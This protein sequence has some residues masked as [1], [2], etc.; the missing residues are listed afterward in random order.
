MAPGENAR[1][2]GEDIAAGSPIRRRRA[3][4]CAPSMPGSPAGRASPTRRSPTPPS[5]CACPPAERGWIEG[6]LRRRRRRGAR[7][8]PAS[9]PAAALVLALGVPSPGWRR[10][11]G[12]ALAGGRGRGRRRGRRPAVLAGPARP[13]AVAALALAARRAGLRAPA[14][15]RRRARPWRRGPLTRKACPPGSA[16]PRSSSSATAA[17]GLEPLA[18]GS[19]PLVALA[20][21]G[22]LSHP[23]AGERGAAARHARR[24]L[25]PVRSRDDPS[26]PL[27]ADPTHEALRQEQ[28]LTVLSRDEALRRFLAALAP[29]PL[30]RESV[31]ARRQRSAACSPRRSPRPPT[32][33]PSTAPASTASPL[34]AADARGGERGLARRRSPSTPRSSPAASRRA[35]RS[36][37]APRRR[38]PPAAPIP[39]GADAVVMVEHTEPR[40]ADGRLLRPPRAGPGPARRLRRLRHRPRRDAAAARHRDRLARDRHARRLR[41]RRGAGLAPAAGRRALDRRRARRG[42]ASRCARPRSTTRTARS[43]PPPSP[44]TAASRC[45][46]ASCRT[47]RRPSRRRCAR[48]HR[49]LRRGDPLRRHLEGGGRS[50]L[51][52]RR[53]ASARPGIVA[54]GVA[55]KPGKPLCLAVC[56]GKPVVVLPGFPTSAM[57]TFHDF[58][59]PVLRRLAGLPERDGG[60]RRRRALPLRVPRNS[61]APSSCMVVPR[62]AARTASSPTRPPRARAPSPPS[63]R[64]T[65]SSR[66]RRSPTTLPAG[67]TVRGARCSRRTAA[68]RPRRHRQPLHRP[69]RRRRTGSPSAASRPALLAVG[70]LGGLAAAA[71]GRVR[72][73]ADPPPRSGDRHLQRALPRGRPRARPGLAAHAGRRLPPGRPALRGQRRA[74][75]RSRAALADP[76]CL[77]VNRNQ[78]AGT[79][80]LIDGLLAGARPDGLLEPA[81]VPQRRRRGGGAGARRL[82]RR[83]RA[84]GAGLR[85]RLPAARRGAL[86]FRR[87][88]ERGA[89]AAGGGGVPGAPVARP[90]RGDRLR[91]LGFTPGGAMIRAA[92]R[93]PPRRPAPRRAGRGRAAR[94]WRTGAGAR[95]LARRAPGRSGSFDQSAIL[96]AIDEGAAL[97]RA[98]ASTRAR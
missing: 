72:P 81:E 32:C 41:H 5:A 62:R 71:A 24:G 63:R 39:R 58:V 52:A 66:S 42:R 89:R 30:G 77:M 91:G 36:R 9:D 8:V 90:R 80:I 96:W 95:G 18:V 85:A 33:R 79:R 43:S 56:D 64:P 51:P 83:D 88:R 50:H 97:A 87:C 22:G 59:A 45:S 98:G 37:P 35:R 28:F 23:A 53:R 17:D 15:P 65:A 60:E 1:G 12:L 86:R 40:R 78:G 82:G 10:T 54:H 34:R 46:S 21:G 38:S 26:R 2:A 68:A 27:S 57:F 31:A 11:G 55:L 25:R 20:A 69:R 61:A 16:R 6:L 7:T 49:R 44:R 75:R 47:T 74:R 4:S 76:A 14:R 84:G 13:A 92:P 73:R 3:R 70:S 19:L 48:R 94:P 67:A 93:L 29:A